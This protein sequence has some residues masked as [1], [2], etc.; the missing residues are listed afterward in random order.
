MYSGLGLQLD[1]SI[2][3]SSSEFSR[4]YQMN[5]LVLTS[6]SCCH[7]ENFAI[8]NFKRIQ[9]HLEVVKVCYSGN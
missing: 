4:P 6:K 1:K 3:M 2:S 7:Q 5:H 8:L 9:R